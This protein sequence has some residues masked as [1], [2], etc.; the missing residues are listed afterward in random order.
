MISS[1]PAMASIVSLLATKVVFSGNSLLYKH[2][3]VIFLENPIHQNLARYN[4]LHIHIIISSLIVISTLICNIP[5]RKLERHWRLDQNSWKIWQW[6]RF[7]FT[8][9]SNAV[10]ETIGFYH[11][12]WGQR[13]IRRLVWNRLIVLWICYYSY[14]TLL[15]GHSLYQALQIE[16]VIKILHEQ[17][18]L[19]HN[20]WFKT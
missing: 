12:C 4:S 9:E 14:V 18:L 15:F 5:W 6:C 19:I 8:K 13:K 10:T 3:F 11:I 17:R 20:T 1:E 2:Y 7:L 16:K